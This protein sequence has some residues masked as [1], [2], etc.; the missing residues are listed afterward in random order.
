MTALNCEMIIRWTKWN[1]CPYKT[2]AIGRRTDNDLNEIGEF[3]A[4]LDLG[5]VDTV[6]ERGER[7]VE[8]HEANDGRTARLV[9]A[10]EGA[11]GRRGKE[12]YTKSEQLSR[13]TDDAIIA[14]CDSK[15]KVGRDSERWT[16]TKN[17]ATWAT[18]LVACIRNVRTKS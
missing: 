2:K 9:L 10:K 11:C 13:P 1:I 12:V 5:L 17:A 7:V 16:E 15:R 6:F 8:P 4:A 18:W 3:D 14:R